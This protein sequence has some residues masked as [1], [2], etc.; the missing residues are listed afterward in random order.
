MSCPINEI[1]PNLF[2]SDSVTHTSNNFYNKFNINL[3]INCSKDL[4]DINIDIL[5]ENNIEYIRIPVNEESSP[6]NC[7]ILKSKIHEICD[8][9]HLNIKNL[10][11]VLIYCY[12]ANQISPTITVAYI[13]KYCGISD[14]NLA[15]YYVRT[16]RPKCFLPRINFYDV[17]NSINK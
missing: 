5:T 12:S 15:I 13:L 4:P 16:K 17:L 10:S 1:L 2:I 6:D 8:K 3:I 11:G 14:I 9:I 7:A